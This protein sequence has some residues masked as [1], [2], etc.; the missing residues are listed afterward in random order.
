MQSSA[1]DKLKSG[2]IK[3]DLDT[4]IAD[5]GKSICLISDEEKFILKTIKDA[6]GGELPDSYNLELKLN[7]VK[8]RFKK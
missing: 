1:V 5:N 7:G 4:G 8:F 3:V 6:L 2:Y